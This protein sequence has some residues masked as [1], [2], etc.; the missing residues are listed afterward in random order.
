MQARLYVLPVHAPMVD[1]RG[2]LGGVCL[3]V[4]GV[5]LVAFYG[6]DPFGYL[7]MALAVVGLLVSYGATQV[8]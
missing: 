3:V 5:P 7:G 1:S 6:F 4:A 8:A 2:L